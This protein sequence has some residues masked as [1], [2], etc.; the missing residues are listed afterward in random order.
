VGIESWSD[1]AILVEMGERL[2]TERLNRNLTIA[3]VAAHAGVSAR[4]LRNVEDGASHSVTTLIRLLRAL[5]LLG[6]IDALLPEPGLSP[7]ELAKLR[8]KPRQR[9]TGRRAADRTEEVWEW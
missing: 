6:R 2:R 5:D 8:G 7:I 1:E 9:A 4:T 3:S